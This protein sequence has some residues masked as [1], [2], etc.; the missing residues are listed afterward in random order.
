MELTCM[1]APGLNSLSVF[2]GF[3]AMLLFVHHKLPSCRGRARYDVFCRQIIF[4]GTRSPSTTFL[5]AQVI[6]FRTQ[7]RD[8]ESKSELPTGCRTS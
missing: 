1:I 3:V 5:V 6:V 2:L 7:G 4:Y 8:V